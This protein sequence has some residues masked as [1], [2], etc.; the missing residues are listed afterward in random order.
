[1]NFPDFPDNETLRMMRELRERMPD[2]AT[3]RMIDDV[4][5]LHQDPVRDAII[6]Q[7]L[8]FR[9]EYGDQIKA[10][11]RTLAETE[12]LKQALATIPAIIASQQANKELYL[13]GV[14]AVHNIYRNIPRETLNSVAQMM[15]QINASTTLVALQTIREL[16]YG[17]LA[18]EFPDFEATI[19]K[20]APTAK[21]KEVRKAVKKY[22]AKK[23][24]R[25]LTP[26]QWKALLRYMAIFS[27]LISVYGVLPKQNATNTTINNTYVVQAIHQEAEIKSYWVQRDCDLKARANF[28]SQTILEFRKMSKSALSIQAASGCISSTKRKAGN[29]QSMVSSIKST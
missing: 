24:K 13:Q 9:N 5:R 12:A 6:R 21:P 8:D 4:R 25:G 27:F 10:I 26:Q 17:N 1:M 16:G 20:E 18:D 22:V 29:F 28:K 11:A 2:S 19:V 15:A 23:K 7:H 3:Q 14:N